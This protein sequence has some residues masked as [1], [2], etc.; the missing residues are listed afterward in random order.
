[1]K[2]KYCS[3]TFDDGPNFE[4][5]DTMDKMLDVL[6]KH[7]VVASFFLIGNKITPENI[8]VIERAVKMGCD[9]ENHTWTHP[10]MTKLT[11]EQMIEEYDK[12]DEAIIK[13][14]GKKPVLFR[15]PYICVNDLMHEV[16]HVPFICGHGCDDWIPDCPAD[17]RYQKMMENTQDGVMYL[18]HVNEGNDATREVVDRAIPALK[19]MGFEFVT[20]PELYRLKNVPMVDNGDNWSVVQ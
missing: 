18:L 2:K 11:K 12:C 7:G 9:I 15:P 14:T 16:I 19:E 10:D 13:I 17:V 3:L 20:A 1:M 8:K 4:G 6:E 5:N